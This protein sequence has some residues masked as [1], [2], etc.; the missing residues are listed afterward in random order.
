M[1]LFP[2]FLII[3]FVCFGQNNTSFVCFG[4]NNT[5][6]D[7][8][9]DSIVYYLKHAQDSF[10]IPYFKKAI[11]LSKD[12]QNDSLL[13]VSSIRYAETSFFRGDSIE[14]KQGLKNLK[15]LYIK[16]ND[17]LVLAKIYHIKA[18]LF[19]RKIKLDSAFFYY[20]Q[21]KNVSLL[22]KDSL[23]GGRRLLSMGL[24]QIN[25][26]DLVG[27]ES[28]LIEALRY[29]EPL[30]ENRFT[31]NTYNNL[32]L[33]LIE[34]KRY[35]EA[36]KYFKNSKSLHENNP[37]QDS[38]ERGFLDYFNNTGFSYLKEGKFREAIP[39]LE[40]G[41]SSFNVKEKYT[42]WHQALLGN[43]ADCLYE[44][45]KKEE[46]WEKYIKLLEIR[47]EKGNIYGQ[48]L[49][50]NGLADF[51]IK[52]SKKSKALFHAKEAYK[53]SKQVNNNA[54]RLSTLLKLGALTEGN[55]SKKHYQEYALLADSL[56]N[57]ERYLKNQFA[58]IRYET[59]KN[60]K[61]KS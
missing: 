41:L 45:E 38:K 34:F 51:Y 50:H 49:S 46:A 40:K 1:K 36:R 32:G 31:G 8:K 25:E 56:N 30:K 18:M 11:Q 23:E 22:K 19:K 13:R 33:V 29:L 35:E 10:H 39:F 9:R 5:S 59:E 43:L 52:E 21:S 15:S 4:Q 26:N 12:A 60:E 16:R 37:N 27:A 6:F 2:F 53:L 14:A 44:L 57:R 55:Q 7:Q 28:S 58:K 47:K 17:S 20:Q 24:M 54:T 3:S 42:F 61:E 48:S